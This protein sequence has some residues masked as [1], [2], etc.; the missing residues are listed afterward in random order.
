MKQEHSSTR[1]CAIQT[2]QTPEIECADHL[3]PIPSEKDDLD[4]QPSEMLVDKTENSKNAR[5][6]N[7]LLREQDENE[8]KTARD[9]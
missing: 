2:Q 1:P 7:L 6:G 5:S 4:I 8:L 3:K 9:P